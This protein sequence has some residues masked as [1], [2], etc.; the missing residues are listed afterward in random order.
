MDIEKG[1]RSAHPDGKG[2]PAI[3]ETSSRPMYIYPV[4][5]IHSSA[6]PS[7]SATASTS[8][9]PST[10]RPIMLPYETRPAEPYGDGPIEVLPGVFLGAEE[11][12]WHWKAARVSKR[13]RVFNVAQEVDDPFERS[14]AHGKG[15][16]KVKL[17]SYPPDSGR[18]GV[19]YCHL[20]WSHGESGLAEL[21]IGV[22]L[23]DLFDPAPTR[24]ER[25]MWGFWDAIR[26]LEA[27]R[28]AGEPILIQY[29]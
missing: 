20:R 2:F 26:W 6:S 12:V 18:P 14:V 13:I 25:E 24:S 5:D 22:R 7:T 29:V 28:R 8:S 27:G 10:S 9:T 17:A 1:F 15:K 16:E 21:P 11:S 19:E 3:D 4:I 23:D